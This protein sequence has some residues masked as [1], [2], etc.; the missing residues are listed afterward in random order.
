MC[1]IRRR[2]PNTSSLPT[3]ASIDSGYT[4]AGEL[5]AAVTALGNSAALLDVQQARGTTRGLDDPGPV[6]PGVVAIQKPTLAFRDSRI[7][8]FH[9]DSIVFGFG[10]EMNFVG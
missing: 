9:D 1:R 3:G 10:R 5:G 2:R 6:G 7:P 8:T 4:Y